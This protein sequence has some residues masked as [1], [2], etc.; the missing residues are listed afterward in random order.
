MRLGVCLAVHVLGET[1]HELR[2]P[3]CSPTRCSPTDYRTP[4]EQP[5][6]AFTPQPA[7]IPAPLSLTP[8]TAYTG[9]VPP[10]STGAAATASLT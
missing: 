5:T 9:S 1:L 2:Q 4:M 6:G 3:P 7:P 10:T 8:S